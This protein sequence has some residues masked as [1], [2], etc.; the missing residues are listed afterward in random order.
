MLALGAGASGTKLIS[1]GCRRSKV[2]V[3]RLYLAIPGG[4]WP[5]RKASFRRCFSPWAPRRPRRSW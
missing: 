4:G 5:N 3:A 1:P 2:K